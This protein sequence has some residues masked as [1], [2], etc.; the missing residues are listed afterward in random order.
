MWNSSLFKSI[1]HFLFSVRKK[2]YIFFLLSKNLKT[3]K[4]KRNEKVK[5]T[6]LRKEFK[7]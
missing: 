1:E 3:K 4:Q 2:L 6:F 5:N 7:S